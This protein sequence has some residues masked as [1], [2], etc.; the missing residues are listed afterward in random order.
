VHIIEKNK[1]VKHFL[2]DIA[3]FIFIFQN[4]LY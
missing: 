4:Y 2:F 3:I 1:K